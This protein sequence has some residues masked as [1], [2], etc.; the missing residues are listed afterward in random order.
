MVLVD[1][2]AGRG[3]VGLVFRAFR[4][5]ATTEST[6]DG[7]NGKVLGAGLF[8]LFTGSSSGVPALQEGD[9]GAV[10]EGVNP[11]TFE[12]GVGFS[13]CKPPCCLLGRF[14]RTFYYGIFCRGGLET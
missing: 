12:R 11:I 1:M 6:G 2:A 9:P 5:S 13:V 7:G 14:I 8:V 10:V 3:A 4:G